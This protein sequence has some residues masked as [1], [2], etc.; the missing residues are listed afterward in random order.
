M[1]GALLDLGDQHQR[2]RFCHGTHRIENGRAVGCPHNPPD[3]V[4][5]QWC[6]DNHGTCDRYRCRQHLWPQDE[7]PGRPHKVGARPPITLRRDDGPRCTL[8]QIRLKPDGMTTDAIGETLH[9]VGERVS[10]LE[11][12]GRL[13][14]EAVRA[15]NDALEKLMPNMPEGSSIRGTFAHNEHALPG[16]H[17]VTVVL[18]V[19]EKA[20]KKLAKVAANGVVRRRVK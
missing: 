14:M 6:Q 15:V 18:D 1:S 20:V 7:R 2:C 4:G 17:F 3:D 12:R 9:V 13:K 5:G 19:D 16:Q 11:F 10:Q 8:H